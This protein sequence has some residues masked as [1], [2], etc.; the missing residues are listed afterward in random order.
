M[1]SKS[2]PTVP[3]GSEPSLTEAGAGCSHISFRARMVRL[4]GCGDLLVH[5]SHGG[6]PGG[7]GGDDVQDGCLALS[8]PAPA[9]SSESFLTRSLPMARPSEPHGQAYDRQ[10]AYDQRHPLANLR[11]QRDQ[12]P[13]G[14]GRAEVSQEYG[15]TARSWSASLLHAPGNNLVK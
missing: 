9:S 13:E 3:R 2:T 1:T 4:P 8:A 15:L 12:S 14:P 5:L 7:L 11:S 10:P 6:V